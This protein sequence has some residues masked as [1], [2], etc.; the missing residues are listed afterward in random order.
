M[1]DGHVQWWDSSVCAGR[2]TVTRRFNQWPHPRGPSEDRKRVLPRDTSHPEEAATYLRSPVATLRY[3]RHRRTG[4][5]SLLVGRRV[6]YQQSDLDAYVEQQI[7][8]TGGGE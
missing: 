2:N 4:P 7:D 1:V 6:M 5:R 3:W 8:K